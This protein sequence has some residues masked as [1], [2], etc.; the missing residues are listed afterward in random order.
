VALTSCFDASPQQ[1]AA[2]LTVEFDPRCSSGTIAKYTW[3]FGD[4]ETS[5]TRQPTHTFDTAGSYQV[6]LE[7]ADNQNVL[8][9]TSKAILVTGTI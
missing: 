5:R 9:T 7:V 3:D 6:T 1:G 2:P 4:G 8:N